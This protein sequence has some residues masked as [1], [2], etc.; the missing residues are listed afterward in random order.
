MLFTSYLIFLISYFLHLSS[1]IPVLG[2]ARFDFLLGVALLLGV[3]FTGK[4]LDSGTWKQDPSKQL[5][6]FVVFAILSIPLVVWP[7]SVIH[8]NL[9]IFIKAIFFFILTITLVDTERKLKIFLGVFLVCQ[10]FRIIEPAYLHITQG[11]WGDV[12]YSHIGGELH[13]LNRLEGAPHDIVNSNQLAWV[14]NNII[15]FLFYLGWYKKRLLWK[16]AVTPLF[17]IIFYALILTGSRSGLISLFVII[18]SILFMSKNKKKAILIG[19]VLLVPAFLVTIVHLSPQLKDRYRSIYEKSAVGADTAGGRISGMKRSLESV[20][21]APIFGHGIGT[22][23][24]AN[25][26]IVGGSAQPTHN[27]YIEILQEVGIVGFFLFMLYI[28]SIITV[29]L[30]IKHLIT[31]QEED[32]FLANLVKALIVWVIMDLVYSLSCFGLS[33]WEWYLFGGMTAAAY[34]LVR[35]R[36]ELEAGI[37]SEDTRPEVLNGR[38]LGTQ[39]R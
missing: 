35:E 8:L 30:S 34:K 39:P 10:V 37:P 32:T 11:Y 9:I 17:I 12:A 19:L 14:A 18:F 6:R 33:S 24:E 21:N 23:R 25:V 15:P 38:K 29:L 36:E 2:A 31:D 3:G 20:L 5:I 27:L 13:R 1:R 22:S 4:L 26:N 16:L 28:K 7:G